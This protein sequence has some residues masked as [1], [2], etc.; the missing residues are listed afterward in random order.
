MNI[1]SINASPT[2]CDDAGNIRGDVTDIGKILDNVD[3]AEGR[4]DAL[5]AYIYALRDLQRANDRYACFGGDGTAID[6]AQTAVCEAFDRL[7]VAE[8]LLNRERGT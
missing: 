6:Q 8:F 7:I 2:V 3:Q 4:N 1:I 5:R